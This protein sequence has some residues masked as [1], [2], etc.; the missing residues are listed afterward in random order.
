VTEPILKFTL[1]KYDLLY[2]NIFFLVNDIYIVRTE[3][4]KAADVNVIDIGKMLQQFQ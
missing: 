3:K 2:S 1:F 4:D